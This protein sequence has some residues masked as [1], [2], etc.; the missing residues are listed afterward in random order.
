MDKNLLVI[1]VTD[2]TTYMYSGSF[3][4]KHSSRKVHKFL[5]TFA[6]YCIVFFTQDLK[7]S[8]QL[9]ILTDRSQGGASLSNGTIELM[10]SVLKTGKYTF[11]SLI[12]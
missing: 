7:R 10:V 11:I 1:H 2:I 4:L 12:Y 3:C 9:T 5:F 8:S 6:F